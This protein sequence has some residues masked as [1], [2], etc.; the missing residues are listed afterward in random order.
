MAEN[1]D[2]SSTPSLAMISSRPAPAR[3]D[4]W[5]E[6]ATSTLIEAW[7]QHYIELNRG[8]LCQKQWQEVADAVKVLIVAM[9]ILRKLGE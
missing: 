4:Y 5:S 1:Q 2:S 7:G 9:D 6:D 8:N 3:E